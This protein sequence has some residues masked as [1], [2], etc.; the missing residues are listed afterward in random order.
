M[1]CAAKIIECMEHKCVIYMNHLV[2][3]YFEHD[4][5]RILLSHFYYFMPSSYEGPLVLD[6]K[7]MEKPFCVLACVDNNADL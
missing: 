7:E 3:M 2:V 5:V 6:L 1:C 4:I